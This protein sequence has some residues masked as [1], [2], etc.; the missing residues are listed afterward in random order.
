MM[1]LSTLKEHFL[2]GRAVLVDVREREEWEA[3]H[4]EDALFLPL[5]QFGA[6]DLRSLLHADKPHYIYCVSGRRAKLAQKLLIPY[7]SEVVALDEGFA[8]LKA[9]GFPTCLD[10]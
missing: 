9:H 10:I 5:S 2:T 7:V 6:L 1:D 3:G 4:V 8:D